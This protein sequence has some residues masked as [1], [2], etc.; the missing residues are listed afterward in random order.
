MNTGKMIFQSWPHLLQTYCLPIYQFREDILLNIFVKFSKKTKIYFKSLAKKP[1]Y[2]NGFP[3]KDLE[4]N[5]ISDFFVKI[6]FFEI[7]C[8]GCYRN[9]FSRHSPHESR[10]HCASENIGAANVGKFCLR[11]LPRPVW[12]V[13]KLNV[14][15]DT[16]VET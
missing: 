10:G 11:C 4:K 9:W 14:T 13:S 15:K 6:W 5:F 8:Y 16:L 7:L 1:V 12:K 2:V 3:K